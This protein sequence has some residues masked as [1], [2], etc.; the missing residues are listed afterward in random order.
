MDELIMD[1]FQFSVYA[2]L[3]VFLFSL[4]FYHF[5]WGVKSLKLGKL[6]LTDDFLKKENKWNI[7]ILIG[8]ILILSSYLGIPL[9]LLWNPVF[10][11]GQVSYTIENRSGEELFITPFA[12]YD[13]DKSINRLPLTFYFFKGSKFIR[14]KPDEKIKIHFYFEDKELKYLLIFNSKGEKKIMEVNYTYKGKSII[15]SLHSLRDADSDFLSKIKFDYLFFS[16]SFLF[17][18]S[19]SYLNTKLL[20]LIRYN[21]R[22]L[23]RYGIVYM[24]SPLG[25]FIIIYFLIKEAIFLFK[26]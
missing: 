18:L 2:I 10:V 24:L 26:F 22:Y 3:Y 25:S 20:F 15:P 16:I 7:L 12:F 5:Y 21:R 14:L 13:G 8:W 9:Y 4:L 1:F 19:L 17:L 23:S 6:S 11:L